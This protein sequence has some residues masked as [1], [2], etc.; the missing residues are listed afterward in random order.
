MPQVRLTIYKKAGESIISF[1]RMSKIGKH[2]LFLQMHFQFIVESPET[3]NSSKA[4]ELL[5]R[6]LRKMVI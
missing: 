6:Q 3:R 2:G 1:E 5:F 4:I